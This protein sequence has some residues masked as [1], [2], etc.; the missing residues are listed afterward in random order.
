MDSDGYV[1]H[2]GGCSFTSHSPQLRDG[3]IELVRSLGGQAWVSYTDTRKGR[4]GWDVWV[5][6]PFN[7]FRLPRKAVRWRN[8]LTP[9]IVIRV[10]EVGFEPVRCITVAAPHHQYLTDGYLPTHNSGKDVTAMQAVAQ[11][12]AAGMEKMG[13]VME[14][15]K[16]A[17]KRIDSYLDP[18]FT[19]HSVYTRAPNIPGGVNPETFHRPVG[20]LEIRLQPG[21]TGRHHRPNG[22]LS[23]WLVGRTTL[24]TRH[25]GRWVSSIHIIPV[26]SLSCPTSTTEN[27]SPRSAATS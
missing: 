25:C 10:E 16:Q 27:S 15:E 13:C 11:A 9:R 22:T 24:P 20:P 12:A 1:D 17:K 4:P 23:Q 18:Y 5:K 8:H 21:P 7:P 14:N 3:L 2:K 6:T 26:S 19:D